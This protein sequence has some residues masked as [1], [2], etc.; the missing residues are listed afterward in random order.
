MSLTIWSTCWLQSAYRACHVALIC[1][2]YHTFFYFSYHH[3][4]VDLFF[5]LMWIITFRNFSS[6]FLVW[7]S[8]LWLKMF[9]FPLLN[10]YFSSVAL[11][12]TVPY[13]MHDW[14]S[15]CFVKIAVTTKCLQTNKQSYCAICYA[16]AEKKDDFSLRGP[17]LLCMRWRP[18]FLQT[19]K[20]N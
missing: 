4:A 12:L 5:S 16:N 17:V 15:A 2:A 19:N 20:Q 1:S 13:T 8:K 3:P 11:Q 7:V 18:M 6:G 10:S 14:G 9:F